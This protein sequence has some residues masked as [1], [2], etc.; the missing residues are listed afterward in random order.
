VRYLA[1]YAS[2]VVYNPSSLPGQPARRGI[3]DTCLVVPTDGEP[4]LIKMKV[5]VYPDHL[6]APEVEVA[7][8]EVKEFDQDITDAIADTVSAKG[9]SKKKIGVAGEDV[10]SA[11][12]MRLIKEKLPEAQFGFADYILQ[13]MRMILSKNEIA[14][15]R[16]T[17]QLADRILKT[18]VEAAKPGIHTRDIACLMSDELIKANAERILFIDSVAGSPRD[19][20]ECADRI[21]QNGDIAQ[22]DLGFA[23]ENGYF[24]DVGRTLVVGKGEKSKRDLVRLSRKVTDFV[25]ASAKSGITGKQWMKKSRKFV[26]EELRTGKYEIPSPLPLM[27]LGDCMAHDMLTPYFGPESTMKLQEGM[28]ISI[29]PWLYI[30]DFGA[31][32]FEELILITKKGGEFLTNYRYDI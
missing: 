23:D 22:F 29:E 14:L 13:E 21:I 26:T 9:L 24:A 10:I 19:W 7:V 28:V 32:K 3:G 4:V 27:F 1:N 30:P 5:P 8:K 15:M 18:A 16:K 17:A 6:F 25:A 31:S 12:L 11:Y 2:P 20:I